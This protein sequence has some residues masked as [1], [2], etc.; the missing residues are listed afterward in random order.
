MDPYTETGSVNLDSSL[1]PHA[2]KSLPELLTEICQ[3]AQRMLK[4]IKDGQPESTDIF[5]TFYQSLG[6]SYN[7]L[8]QELLN[9]LLNFGFKPSSSDKNS[10]LF[11]DLSSFVSESSPSL[12][13]D[14]VSG[15]SYSSLK[16][17]DE[18]EKKDQ[19]AYMLAD[20]F[21]DELRT[22]LRDLE[23]RNTLVGEIESKLSDSSDKIK[24]LERELDECHELL[25]V[26]EVEVS[27]LNEML[28]EKADNG[29]DL[30]LNTLR[31]ELR[32]RDVQIEQM[33][34]YLNQV[35]VKDTEL[36]SDDESGTNKSVVEELKSRV[37]EL[38]NQV[39]KQRNVISEREEEKREAIR[40]LCVSL[41]HYKSRYTEL[42]ISLSGNN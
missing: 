36:L 9:G 25:E 23:E 6:E 12:E 29:A 1:W 24:T 8:N 28:T 32:S 13:F 34:E 3:K 10:I 40:E 15:V 35:C 27:K 17:N 37:E 4:L 20:F 26:S 2:S 16:L 7:H 41:D 5:L 22:A 33:E 18:A 39:E 30:L 31:A 21:S 38:E 11:G 19:S 14:L 42:V